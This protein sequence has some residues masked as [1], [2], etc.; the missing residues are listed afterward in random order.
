MKKTCTRIKQLRESE[1]MSQIQFG[2]ALGMTRDTVSNLENGRT[3]IKES[4]LKLI[5]ST[6]KVSESWL[7][8][9]EGE[10]FDISNKNTIKAEAFCAIDE[11]E[12]LAKA[13]LE[14]SKLTDE[15]LESILK[16]L[17]VFS[18]E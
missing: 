17:E 1:G 12:K 15:Q 8:T 6:F 11:N 2:E 7:R 3:K 9:G 18:K 10:M 14:F 16:I 5:I 13:V 4:D